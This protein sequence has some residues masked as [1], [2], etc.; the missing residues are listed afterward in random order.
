MRKCVLLIILVVT[1]TLSLRSQEADSS[2]WDFHVST[3]AEIA[4]GFGRTQSIGWVSPSIE[5]K[6]NERLTLRTGLTAFG[7]LMPTSFKLQGRTQPSYVRNNNGTKGTTLWA[8]AEYK[9]SDHLWLWADVEHTSG[10]FQPLWANRG[11]PLQTTAFS[12]GMGYT[13]SDRSLFEMQIHIIRETYQNPFD[14]WNT[15]HNAHN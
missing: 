4:S 3:G 8:S 5:Y 1:T 6:A 9:V 7:S 12:G 13:F 14:S 10:Y 11:I 2:K 15:T